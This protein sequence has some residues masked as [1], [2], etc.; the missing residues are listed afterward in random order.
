MENYGGIRAHNYLHA[1]SIYAEVCVQ[2]IPPVH[3]TLP[4]YTYIYTFTIYIDILS[5]CISYDTNNM[6]VFSF[7]GRIFTWRPARPHKSCIFNFIVIVLCAC[8]TYNI[9]FKLY[10]S[11]TD[12]LRPSVT[13]RQDLRPFDDSHCMRIIIILLVPISYLCDGGTERC[14]VRKSK[15]YIYVYCLYDVTSCGP[16]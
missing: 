13:V 6:C 10:G 12:T 8:V 9:M 5:V 11:W 7:R 1:H 4:I 14:Q 2:Q 16:A 15:Q 3:N